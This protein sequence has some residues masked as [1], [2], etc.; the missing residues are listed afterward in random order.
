MVAITNHKAITKIQRTAFPSRF[1]EKGDKTCLERLLEVSTDGADT[2]AKE[3]TG[4]Q[5]GD[6]SSN[7]TLGKSRIRL[8]KI[9]LVRNSLP[10]TR[11]NAFMPE[12]KP[13]RLTESV[14]AAG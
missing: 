6:K 1:G 9:V 7:W 12:T 8:R 3:K 14:K 10:A 4:R 11:Y 13:F 5:E 2:V